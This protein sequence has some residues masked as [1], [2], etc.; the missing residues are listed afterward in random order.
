M[1]AEAMR[2]LALTVDEYAVRPIVHATQPQ[3]GIRCGPYDV[4]AYHLIVRVEGDIV[5]HRSFWWEWFVGQR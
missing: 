3:G 4:M 2:K 1:T 5:G